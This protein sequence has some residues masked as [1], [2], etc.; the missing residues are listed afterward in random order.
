MRRQRLAKS[1][2]RKGQVPT[3]TAEPRP[4]ARPLISAEEVLESISDAFYAVDFDWRFT[5]VNRVA[6]AWWGRTR[7]ELIGRHL[8]TEMPKAVGSEPYYAHLRA[9]EERKVVRLEAMSPIVGHWVDISIFP[10]PHGLSVY[11]RDVDERKQ[12]DARQKLLVNELNHRVK[13]TLAT[14]QAIAVQTFKGRDVP[15]EVRKGFMDRLTALAEANDLVVANNWTG[16]GM[17]ELVRRVISPHLGTGEGSPFT[18]VGPDIAL[19]PR[20]A[21]SLALGLHELATNAAKHGALATTAGAVSIRWK[22]VGSGVDPEMRIV[23]AESGGARVEPPTRKG[24][25]TRLLKEG[26]RTDLKATVDIRYEPRGLVCTIT[27]PL[28]EVAA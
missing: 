19:K 23:W 12:E 9:A 5:Y 7:Q 13:N 16:A 11:F 21:A 15:T 28:M 10:N 2:E 27:A 17:L 26:L 24:F 18:I 22:V 1:T 3:R 20:A 8:W 4:P 25:G 14:V 6:E